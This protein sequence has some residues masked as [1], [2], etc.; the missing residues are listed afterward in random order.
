M[1]KWRRK[2]SL[3][4]GSRWWAHVRSLRELLY[5]PL[6]F[7]CSYLTLSLATTVRGLR[8]CTPIFLKKLLSGVVFCGCLQFVDRLCSFSLLSFEARCDA[9]NAE[10]IVGR[11]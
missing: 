7:W 4:V 8:G 11:D 1:G 10:A 6:L 2:I 9:I 3:D 5:I